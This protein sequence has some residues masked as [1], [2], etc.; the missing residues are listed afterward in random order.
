MRI[1]YEPPTP[2]LVIADGHWLIYYDK[3]LEEASY[4]ALEGSLAGF[5]L[6]NRIRFGGDVAVA[7]VE[8]AKGVVRLT[9]TRAEE[10]DAGRLTLVFSTGPLELRQWAV[11]DA[12]GADTRVALLEPRFGVALDR[13]LFRFT[14]PDGDDGLQP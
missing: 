3:E 11:R 9:L 1:E 6:R 12:T 14:P 4:T 2:Y 8:R 10:P 7:D 5:L 13:D